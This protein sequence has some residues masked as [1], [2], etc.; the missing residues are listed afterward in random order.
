MQNL[1]FNKIDNEI[2]AYLLGFYVGDGSISIR[3]NRKEY[4]I[5]FSQVELD[6]EIIYLIQDK[7]GNSNILKNTNI[8]CIFNNKSYN[9]QTS[10]SIT[11]YSRQMVIDLISLGYGLHK[12]CRNLHLP[13]YLNNNLI[14]HF[15]R[16][17]FDADG[18]CS[19]YKTIRK[20]RP[21][22]NRIKPTFH[23]TSKTSSLL[24]EIQTFLSNN[25]NI[26]IPLYYDKK[27]YWV[28]KS[29][30]IRET[31]KLYILL[32]ENAN[33]YITRKKNKFSNVMLTSS[34]FR[35]LKDSEPCN[36]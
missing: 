26:N 32:Y 28:L 17:Y 3:K 25:Y 23:I 33:Y 12:T 5:K 15:I 27:N 11:Y 36:A 24:K 31:R 20:D 14:I 19:M 16:G 13:K 35:K 10:Y 9:C 1:F 7:I 2:K 29:G 8:K 18:T 30:S 34:E 21:I 4:S 6:K 22:G